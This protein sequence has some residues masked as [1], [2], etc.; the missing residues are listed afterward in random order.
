MFP[1]PFIGEEI[2]KKYETYSGCLD[3]VDPF[4]TVTPYQQKI[5]SVQKIISGQEEA[6]KSIEKSIK[7]DTSIGDKIY[8]HYSEIQNLL[9]VVKSLKKEQ[10]WEE[11]K[12]LLM[13][14]KRINKVDLKLK[15]VILN[16]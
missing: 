4:E 8:D 9:N 3:L 14:E 7:K 13:K 5:N 15:K 2:N 12:K 1:L 10:S 16:L 11:I 6:I